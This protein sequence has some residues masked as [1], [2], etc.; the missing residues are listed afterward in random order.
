MTSSH[1][2]GPSKG[3]DLPQAKATN[4]FIWDTVIANGA[5]AIANV[6]GAGGS[7]AKL[8]ATLTGGVSADDE[9]ML[10]YTS[11]STGKPKGVIHTQRSVGTYRAPHNAAAQPAR[12]SCR[13]QI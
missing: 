8:E 1:S 10:M 7:V 11:G 6:V 3:A 9:A 12:V 5:R 2:E 4:A 13:L